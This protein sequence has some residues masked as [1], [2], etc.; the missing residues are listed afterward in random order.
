MSRK[1]V[2]V[3]RSVYTGWERGD[4]SSAEWAHPE[5]EFILVG[6]PTPGSW[7]GLAGMAEGVHG[8]LNAWEDWRFAADEYR[9]LDVERVLVLTSYRGRGKRS[10][11]DVGQTRSKGASVFHVCGGRVPRLVAYLNREH[12]FA[13]LGLS[14]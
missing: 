4:Y 11:L 12:A 10:G 9:E 13:D 2:E 14:E 5:I 8:S 1:N 3:A 7:K 6:G